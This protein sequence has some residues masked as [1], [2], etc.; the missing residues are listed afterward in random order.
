MTQE[1]YTLH[2]RQLFIEKFGEMFLDPCEWDEDRNCFKE[3]YVHTAWLSWQ[4]AMNSQWIDIK[5]QP[6]P[7]AG[8]TVLATEGSTVAMVTPLAPKGLT[9]VL[10]HWQ[11][12]PIP[13]KDYL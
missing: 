12:L 10:L 13:P 7:L 6:L 8:E 4:L 3:S 2:Q 11:P 5:K 1:E 9:K